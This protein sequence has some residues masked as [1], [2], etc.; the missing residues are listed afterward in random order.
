M[1]VKPPLIFLTT[2][3][4]RLRPACGN[5][6][7][8]SS[9]KSSKQNWMQPLAARDMAGPQAASQAASAIAT[10]TAAAS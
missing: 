5:G 1:T 4:I 8:A 2:G 6:F 3:S 9:S 7:A 10:V